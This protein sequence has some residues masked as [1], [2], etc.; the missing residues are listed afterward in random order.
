MPGKSRLISITVWAY[1]KKQPG[2]SQRC[3]CA[4]GTCCNSAPEF[5][6]I[7]RHIKL[8]QLCPSVCI[9]FSVPLLIFCVYYD[10]EN[11]RSFVS[12]FSF[13]ASQNFFSFFLRLYSFL[14]QCRIRIT[15]RSINIL[16]I[17]SSVI[18][19]GLFMTFVH[20]GI[21]MHRKTTSSG[22]ILV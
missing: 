21:S 8:H 17:T 11:L 1:T 3:C 19:S 16:N 5:F 14:P 6:L 10:F 20:C 22:S 15:Y 18:S 4:A 9:T 13:S 7:L 2:R 12:V